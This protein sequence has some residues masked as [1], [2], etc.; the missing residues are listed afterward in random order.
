MKDFTY[1]FFQAIRRLQL[2][3]INGMCYVIVTMVCPHVRGDNPR[4]LAS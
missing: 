2:V 3:E 1:S 4:A